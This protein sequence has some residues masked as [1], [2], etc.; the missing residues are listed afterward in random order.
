MDCQSPTRLS[1][2]CADQFRQVPVATLPAGPTDETT[3]IQ[4]R[5]LAFVAAHRAITFLNTLSNH[6]LRHVVRAVEL[7]RVF[8]PPRAVEGQALPVLGPVQREQPH[9]IPHRGAAPL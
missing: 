3:D 4:D 5:S 7:R 2:L 8:S 6:L 9:P 1:G